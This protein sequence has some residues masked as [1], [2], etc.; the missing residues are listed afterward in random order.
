MTNI[1]GKTGFVLIDISSMKDYEIIPE[2]SLHC[3]FFDQRGKQEW[4]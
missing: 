3:P 1:N 4:K 2:F